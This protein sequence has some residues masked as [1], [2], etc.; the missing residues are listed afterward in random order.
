M[1]K[2]FNSYQ[3]QIHVEQHMQQ[4]WR[5]HDLMSDFEIEDVWRLPIVLTADQSVADVRSKLFGSLTTVQQTGVAG[6]LFQ[7]RLGLG[8]VFGWD[9]EPDMTAPDMT[10]PETAMTLQPGSLRERYAIA[11]G[12]TA[13]QL[14]KPTG[15]AFVP[16]YLL[17]HESLDEIDN[18]TVHAGLH[19]GRVSLDGGHFTVQMAIYVKPKGRWGRA[20]MAL[21]KPFRYWIVYPA[22]MRVVEKQWVS[23]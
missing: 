22:M 11:E 1:S 21:I 6:F 15:A 19:L 10:V 16:V 20:Y 5:A 17:E 12:L 13:E 9:A 7:L 18:A 2:S 3:A 4:P 8:R 14:P 23:S